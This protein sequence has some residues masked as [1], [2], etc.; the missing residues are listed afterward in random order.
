MLTALQTM[1]DAGGLPFSA[2]ETA[3]A[4]ERWRKDG[5][6]PLHHSEI[7]RQN[8]APASAIVCKAV[9]IASSLS[10]PHSSCRAE[11]AKSR[12]NVSALKPSC[13]MPRCTRQ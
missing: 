9:S 3:E 4:V 5:F 2:Q 6:P 11:R 12:A 13:K 1:A 7:F 8:Y 10:R